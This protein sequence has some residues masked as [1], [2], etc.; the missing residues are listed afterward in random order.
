MAFDPRNA[1]LAVW[2]RE[3]ATDPKF[4]KPITGKGFGGTALNGTYV[5]K[6]LTAAFGPVGWGWGYRVIAFDDVHFQS[7]ASLNFCHIEFWYFPFGRAD[8][9]EQRR[10]AFEQVGGTELAG[11]RSSG[12]DYADDEARKK[13]LTDAILKAASHIGIG[14]DIH[15]GMFD[16]SKY[17]DARAVAEKQDQDAIKRELASEQAERLAAELLAVEEQLAVA[18]NA[19]DY[20]EVKDQ[21]AL[22]WP[23]MDAGQKQKA[24]ELMTQARRRLQIPDPKRAA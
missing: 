7:G 4:T 14:G 2:V 10:A 6:R 12:K 1:N 23:R 24:T 8:E 22:L 3:E 18:Q 20:A 17:V 16:D 9:K 11:K 15:L 5:M 21:I 13:S 19:D